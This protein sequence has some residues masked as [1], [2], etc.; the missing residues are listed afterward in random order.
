MRNDK[1]QVLL[2]KQ[3]ISELLHT[4]CRALDRCDRAML[5]SI[6]HPESTHEMSG[7]KGSSKDFCGFAFDALATFQYSQHLLGNVSITI[8]GDTAKADSYFHAF[9]R[10]AADTEGEGLLADH[11]AGVDEDLFIA[12]RYIDKLERRHGAWKII[13]R[14]GVLDWC[15]WEHAEDRNFFNLRAG[16]YGKRDKSDRYYTV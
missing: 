8:D 13:H 1:L 10:I 3:E 2:D 14:C 12:G 15:R 4:Y 7:F 5:E 6:F 9:H 16:P 11:T